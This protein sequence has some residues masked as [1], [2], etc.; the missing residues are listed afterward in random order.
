MTWMRKRKKRK[1][2]TM[3]WMSKRKKRKKRNT[4]MWKRSEREKCGAWCVW[5]LLC[6]VASGSTEDRGKKA[7][8]IQ[9][10]IEF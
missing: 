8:Y 10:N 5:A 6:C 1:T 9:G 2:V 7:H 3:A 4:M